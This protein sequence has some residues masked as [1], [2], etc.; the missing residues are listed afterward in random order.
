MK[1]I[2]TNYANKMVDGRFYSKID[3]KKPTTEESTDGE[4]GYVFVPWVMKEHTEESLKDYKEFMTKY[5]KEHEVCPKCGE[6]SHSTT[7]M[8]Y[9]LNSEKR[10]EYKDLNTC[11]CS[12]C[13]DR[14]SAHER[15]SIE[16]FNENYDKKSKKNS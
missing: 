7:L 2:K 6:K 3:I 14:H 15:I 13:K 11:V 5:N 10:E 12:K 16:Q 9:I 1:K 8:G 4:P